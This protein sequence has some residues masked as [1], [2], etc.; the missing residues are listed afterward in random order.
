MTRKLSKKTVYSA[1]AACILAV[2]IMVCVVVFVLVPQRKAI[3]VVEERIR[4]VEQALVK[5]KTNGHSSDVS[6][7]KQELSSASA[8]L[9]RY[10]ISAGQASDLAVDIDNIANQAGVKDLRSTNRMQHSYGPI[11]EC[12]HVR[13]G[14]IQIDF[15]SSFSQFAKFINSLERNKPVIFV[16]S[17]KIKR[18]DT[19]SNRHDV[20]MV[21]T[22]F[23]GQDSLTDIIAVDDF[24]L[25]AP[26]LASGSGSAVN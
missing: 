12:R 15:K 10:V 18:S 25:S 20:D 26:G 7:L 5:P 1:V 21:L 19:D 17:F 11:N 13:E 4:E 23:V 2:C 8:T 22:F 9:S 3:G 24:S 14:R 6:K 16:D